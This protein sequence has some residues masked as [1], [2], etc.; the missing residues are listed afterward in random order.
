MKIEIL[1][2]DT[3]IYTGEASLVQFPGTEGSFE[4][5]HNHAPIIA[6]LKAGRIKILGMVD[7]TPVFFEINGGVVEVSDNHILVLAE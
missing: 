7:K 5:M 6:T 1:T 2:P 3:T 4:V